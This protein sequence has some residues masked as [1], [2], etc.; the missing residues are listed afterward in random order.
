[1][2]YPVITSVVASTLSKRKNFKRF[3][4]VFHLTC[5]MLYLNINFSVFYYSILH[6][7]NYDR[8]RILMFRKRILSKIMASS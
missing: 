1:M 2:G 4:A 5:L 6:V 7:F 3:T 8:L